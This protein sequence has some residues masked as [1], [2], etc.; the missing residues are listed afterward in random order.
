MIVL[1]VDLGGLCPSWFKD[2]SSHLDQSDTQQRQGGCPQCWAH[3]MLPVLSQRWFLYCGLQGTAP[4]GM[5]FQ[6][7]LRGN[8]NGIK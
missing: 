8:F 7:C 4:F 6:E 5:G 2:M 1:C 3:Q